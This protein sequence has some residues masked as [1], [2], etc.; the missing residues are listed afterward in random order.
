MIK[1]F[2]ALFDNRPDAMHCVTIYNG[3]QE[4]IMLQSYKN[5]YISEEHLHAMELCICLGLKVQV[6]GLENQQNSQICQSTGIKTGRD[7]T[8]CTTGCG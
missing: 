8:Y 1:D 2:R 5:S 4:F 6:E 7:G 3:T